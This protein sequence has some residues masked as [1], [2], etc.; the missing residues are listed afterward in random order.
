MSVANGSLLINIYKDIFINQNFR[1]GGCE[2]LCSWLF[3]HLHCI[4]SIKQ[5]VHGV[6]LWVRDFTSSSF[7]VHSPSVS[8]LSQKVTHRHHILKR[9]AAYILISDD[10]FIGVWYVSVGILN[11]CGGSSSFL[12]YDE[13]EKI[14]SSK[15][16]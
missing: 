5:L 8:V 2:R 7:H 10:E 16:N 3:T 1:I 15:P 11:D 4:L 9:L 12:L 14:N 13:H 6:D